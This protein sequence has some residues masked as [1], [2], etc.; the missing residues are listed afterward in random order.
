MDIIRNK[1]PTYLQEMSRESDFDVAVAKLVSDEIHVW[2][3]DKDEVEWCERCGK[4]KT[5]LMLPD[6]AYTF[7]P[8]RGFI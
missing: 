8:C 2:W 3:K 4:R 1:F 6:K 5:D 7:F